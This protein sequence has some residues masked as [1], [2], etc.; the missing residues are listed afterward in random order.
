M[1]ELSMGAPLADDTTTTFDTLQQDWR[2]VDSLLLT[3][4][5]YFIFMRGA[6]EDSISYDSALP[7]AFRLFTTSKQSTSLPSYSYETS[8]WLS[9]TSTTSWTTCPRTGYQSHGPLR[10]RPRPHNYTAPSA[11]AS[12]RSDHKITAIFK[13]TQYK[14]H[15]TDYRE[16]QCQ[17]PRPVHRDT[18]TRPRENLSASPHQSH[19]SK[20]TCQNGGDGC[21]KA[22]GVMAN[23]WIYSAP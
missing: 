5:C 2:R 18:S 16:D 11:R 1:L 19:A 10:H 7:C 12:C 21:Y 22:S 9:R 20:R 17:M 13:L 4:N 15:T 6:E 23:R 14:E 8:K 3:C